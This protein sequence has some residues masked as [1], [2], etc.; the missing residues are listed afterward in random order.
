MP[1][2]TEIHFK[3]CSGESYL[4]LDA[5]NNLPI[6]IFFRKGIEQYVQPYLDCVPVLIKKTERI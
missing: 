2:A 3:I 4:I 1:Q 6:V 5:S